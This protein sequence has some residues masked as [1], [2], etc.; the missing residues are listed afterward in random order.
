[1]ADNI[2]ETNAEAE[3]NNVPDA[4]QELAQNMALALGL[5]VPETNQAAQTTDTNN[6]QTQ[7]VVITNGQSTET[8]N[9]PA[10]TSAVAPTFEILKEK[11]QYQSPEDAIKE[12]D[13]YRKYKENPV[14]EI[15][16]ENEESKKLFEVIKAGKTKE[17]YAIQAKQIEL[18]ELTSEPITKENAEKV[19]KTAMKYKYGLDAELIDRR[20]NKQFPIPKQPKVLDTETDAEFEERMNDWKEEVANIEKDKIIEANILK[21]ELESHKSKLVLPDIDEDVDPDYLAWKEQ[22]DNGLRL[23]EEAVQAYKTFT[24]KT[25]ETKIN[26]NDE[27]NKVA[28]EFQ[29]EPSVE[30]FGKAV[31]MVTNFDNFFKQFIGQDGKPDRKGFLE[32]IYFALNKDKIITDAINQSKN[33]TIKSR[34]PNNNNGNG[35]N[36]QSP[37]TMEVSELDAQMNLALNGYGRRN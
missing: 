12:I 10:E 35:L 4:S 11:Y 14:A 21:P 27:A 3:L 1:M 6:Q 8:V 20:F 9:A 18:E 29:H 28:F 37:Q 26:F 7:E 31:D 17:A 30:D 13:E 34:I 15:E 19:I 25:I 2:I 16:F 23:H 36:R 33:A 32:A 5:K 24:P 22:Q